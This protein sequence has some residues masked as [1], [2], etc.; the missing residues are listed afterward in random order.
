MANGFTIKFDVSEVEAFGKALRQEGSKLHGQ[1]VQA[2]RSTALNIQTTAKS[3]GYVPVLTGNLK[4]DL[5][6]KL[7]A[8]SGVISAIFGSDLDYASIQEF[9]GRTGNGGYIKPHEYYQ[10]AIMDNED[11]LRERLK[12]AL[13]IKGLK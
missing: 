9:G 2:V 12:K 1:L 8:G 13:A 5:T 3:P 6:H 10:R 7:K 4:R 11:K